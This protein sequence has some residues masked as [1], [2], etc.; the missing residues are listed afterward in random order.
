MDKL[1]NKGET[2]SDLHDEW[3]HLDDEEKIQRFKELPH[4]DAEEFFKS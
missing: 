3:D 4:A 2:H 1:L